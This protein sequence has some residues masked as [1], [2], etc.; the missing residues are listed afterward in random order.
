MYYKKKEI[1]KALY[2]Y[3]LKEKLADAALI[4]KWKKNGYEK[5]CCLRCISSAEHNFEGN[6]ICRV[7]KSER[8]D[9]VI[10]CTNCGCSGC[11]SC[12]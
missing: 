12:D 8:G 5:L 1:S 7:P 4:S 2:D 10:E 11:A 3:C 9:K 6:C